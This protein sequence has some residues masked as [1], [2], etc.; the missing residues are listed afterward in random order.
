MIICLRVFY[1]LFIYLLI[2]FISLCNLIIFF[3]FFLLFRVFHFH[4]LFRF[5]S[6]V[7]SL[8]HFLYLSIIYPRCRPVDGTG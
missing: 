4:V 6:T 8:S 7:I 5:P 1:Y 2:T 3:C